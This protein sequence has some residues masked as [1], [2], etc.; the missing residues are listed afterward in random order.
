MRFSLYGEKNLNS[1]SEAQ[2]NVRV[3]SSRNRICLMIMIEGRA[4]ICGK[5]CQ[6]AFSI[7]KQ[8]DGPDTLFH[9]QLLIC[10]MRSLILNDLKPTLNVHYRERFFISS[11]SREAAKK[12]FLM[13]LRPYPPPSSLMA[14][15]FFLS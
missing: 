7:G 10:I 8:C 14:V 6:P 13:P 1:I 3:I 4:I 2:E 15:G 11:L 12:V 5:S 9:F